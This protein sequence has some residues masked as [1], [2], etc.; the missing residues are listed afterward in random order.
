[1]L[2]K[3][4]HLNH[5]NYL[6]TLSGY[7]H[8]KL[9]GEKVVGVSDASGMFP[10]DTCTNSYHST[11]IERFKQLPLSKTCPWSI[12]NILP[13][14]LVAVM[15]TDRLTKEGALL[16]DPS[17]TLL[18]DISLCPPEEDAG[19]GMVTTNTLKESTGNLSA[20]TFIFSKLFLSKN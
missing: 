6:T 12:E 14:T 3:E 17:G 1:M 7:I 15:K 19:T 9:T 2:N 4:A 16:L 10:V 18:S 11:M 13:E 8:W 20:G 5:I